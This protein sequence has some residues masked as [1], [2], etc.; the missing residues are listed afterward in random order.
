M[1]CNETACSVCKVP[2]VL[3]SGVCSI[4]NTLNPN[5][6][7]QAYGC[8]V[9]CNVCY[10]F[11]ACYTCI[12]GFYITQ[13]LKCVMGTTRIWNGFPIAYYTRAMPL[14]VLNTSVCAVTTPRNVTLNLPYTTVN[15]ANTIILN[16]YSQMFIG[17][18]F[19]N[20]SGSNVI[21]G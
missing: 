9:N 1:K 8:D 3:V 13:T 5:S 12:S 16:S 21:Y 10:S 17:N 14:I 20:I 6:V 7:P 4:N 19:F 2:Y 15:D 11:D 18:A